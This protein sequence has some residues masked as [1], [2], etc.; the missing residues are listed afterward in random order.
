MI[1]RFF[2]M[3]WMSL[4]LLAILASC[5]APAPA[6]SIEGVWGRLSPTTPGNGGV[7]MLIKNTGSAA[8]H[9]VSAKSAACGK[10]EV[11][12]MVTRADGTSGMNLIEKP[13]E[14]PASGQVE[15]K[16]GGYH[17]MCMMMKADQF[18][19]GNKVDFTLVFEKSGEKT[20]TAEIRAE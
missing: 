6:I 2:I 8:D 14:V 16:V 1:K 10:T 13:L 15:L 3:G 7:Y 12:E 18:K 11:H 20:V 4:L 5:A 9:L 19:P 17:V